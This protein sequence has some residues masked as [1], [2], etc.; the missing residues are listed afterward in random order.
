TG[1]VCEKKEKIHPKIKKTVKLIKK[2]IKITP[3][4]HAHLVKNIIKIDNKRTSVRKSLIKGGHKM[5]PKKKAEKQLKLKKLTDLKKKNLAE[6]KKIV[7]QKKYKEITKTLKA[8]NK[9]ISKLS[10]KLA[11]K[12]FIK[13]TK[14][15]DKTE[16]HPKIKKTVKIIKKVIKSVPKKHRKVVRKII[17]IDYKRS[18]IKKSLAKHGAKISPPKKAEKELKL[19]N[20]TIQKKKHL[21]ELKKV[22]SHK[23]YKKIIKTITVIKKKVNTLPPK[24]AKKAIKK[25]TGKVCEKKEKIHPKIKK[26]VKIIKKVIKSVPKEHRKVVKKIIKI[27]Y[28][29]SVIKKSLA[30]HDQKKKYIE[31][32]KKKV[33]PKKFDKITKTITVIKKKVNKLPP[34]L[35]KKAIKKGTGKVCEKKEK[36]HPKIKKTVKIIKKVIKSVPKEHRKVVKKIIKIDYKRSVIKK[37]LAKHG[38]KISP[39]KKAEKELKLKKL[40]DQKKKYIE[41]LKKKVEPKKFDKITKTITVIKKKVN[42]LPPKLAKKAIKKGIGKMSSKKTILLEKIDHTD[43]KLRKSASSILAEMK[44]NFDGKPFSRK[45]ISQLNKLLSKTIEI[46]NKQVKK[47]EKLVGEKKVITLGFKKID[48]KKTLAEQ[49]RLATKRHIQI[50]KKLGIKSKISSKIDNKT[51]KEIGVCIDECKTKCYSKAGV[52]KEKIDSGWK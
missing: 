6:L 37:S 20:L 41:I 26:T 40:T 13:G 8:I 9:N 25:G 51:K 22:V 12:A 32:L 46:R 43:T 19:K 36:I 5:D 14:K 27:D 52:E 42:T 31:I 48:S 34:K 28:K 2:A 44:K 39:P 45:K 38:A 23:K 30:K 3:K 7:I 10:P 33:E 17:K 49:I 16:V 35:A 21:E 47:L 29:R 24:L 1:K 18:V 4:K 15:Q 50:K 11:N